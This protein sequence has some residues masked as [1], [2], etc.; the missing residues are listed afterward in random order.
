MRPRIYRDPLHCWYCG[1][2][3]TIPDLVALTIDDGCRVLFCRVE[4]ADEHVLYW[5]KLFAYI[6]NSFP[7]TLAAWG[8]EEVT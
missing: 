6:L 2:D 7:D 1:K 3:I 5:A 4:C 8:Y